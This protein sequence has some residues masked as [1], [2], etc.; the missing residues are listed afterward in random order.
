MLFQGQVP[1][2]KLTDRFVEEEDSVLLGTHS[3]WEGVD[4]PGK[5]LSMVIIP[6]IPFRNVRGPFMVKVDELARKQE[7]EVRNDPSLSDSQKRN[8]LWKESPFVGYQMPYATLLLRQGIG[9]L[10]RSGNDRGVV[11]LLDVRLARF[12]Y[13]KTMQKAFPTK[14]EEVSASQMGNRA[15]AF[16]GAGK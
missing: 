14:V 16:Y 4:V 2:G 8:I 7:Q 5:A 6:R 13:G 12:G 3:F 1:R 9:R 11:A 10:I 15:A